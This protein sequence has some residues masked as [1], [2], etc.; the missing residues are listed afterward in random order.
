MG[1][2]GQSRGCC[3]AALSHK[4]TVVIA[5]RRH[6]VV[7][8]PWIRRLPELLLDSTLVNGN[9]NARVL[10]MEF[11]AKSCC[12]QACGQ[13]VFAAPPARV[14]RGISTFQCETLLSGA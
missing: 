4:E 1:M 11:T 13:P 7:S 10:V 2:D 8:M 6:S 9:G 3:P 12:W 14:L 5:L